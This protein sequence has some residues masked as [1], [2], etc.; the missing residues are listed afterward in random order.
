MVD[1]FGLSNMPVAIKQPSEET[2]AKFSRENVATEQ[3]IFA[4]YC[5]FDADEG[6][7]NVVDVGGW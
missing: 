1:P 3:G 2:I 6:V 7:F 4:T 5:F